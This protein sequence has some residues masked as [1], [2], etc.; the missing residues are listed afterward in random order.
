MRPFLIVL[1]ASVVM[2]GEPLPTAPAGTVEFHGTLQGERFWLRLNPPEARFA[3]Q[4][5]AELLY[6]PPT[7]E[8]LA[9]A[10]VSDCPFLLLDGN[11]RL[12]AW[13]GRDTLAAVVAEAR[14]Y[15][16]TRQLDGPTL[17]G[18]QITAVPDERNVAGARGWDERL[19][20][21]LLAIAWRSGTSG[22]VPVYDFFGAQ[23]AASALTWQDTTITIAGRT[24]T[25]VPDASGRLA[26]LDDAAGAHVLTI[27]AWTTP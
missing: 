24:L 27:A 26:H 7:P 3:N 10:H 9:G 11:L 16:V 22:N 15:K 17:E 19:A 18:N 25:A 4:R 21:L 20:P 12:V 6:T 1:L 5:M 13:N 14:G 23:P 8:V 2:A